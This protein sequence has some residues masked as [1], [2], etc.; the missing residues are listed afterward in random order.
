MTTLLARLSAI[1]LFAAFA[2]AAASQSGGPDRLVFLGADPAEGRPGPIDD[3]LSVLALQRLP[4][5]QAAGLE[6]LAALLRAEPVST[7]IA[8]PDSS[9]IVSGDLSLVV[10]L[11]LGG[12]PPG[13]LS[14]TVGEETLG[15]ETLGERLKALADAFNPAARQVAF[16]RVADGGDRFPAALPAL[17]AALESTGVAMS[18]VMVGAGPC[19]G[20]RPGLHYALLGGLPDRPPFGDGDGL[21]SAD[22]ART[23]LAAAL[24]REVQRA[25]PCA[26]R[27]SLIL[28][29]N[30]DPSR[31]LV[32]LPDVPLIPEM[33]S[34]VYMEAF[35]A[36]F[37]MSSDDDAAIRT[38]LE[39]C[40]FCPRE[41]ELSSRLAQ[42]GEEA[43][44]LSLETRR[45]A[46]DHRRHRAR[47]APR[48]IS[49]TASSAPS[50]S[51]PKAHRRA[52]GRRRRPR[53]RGR[54]LRDS[55]RGARSARPSGLDRDSASPATARPT[56]QALIDDIEADDRVPG[57]RA[58]LKS[59][60]SVQQ[61]RRNRRLAVVLRD[62]RRREPG[63][64]RAARPR[65][66]GSGRRALH[67]RRRPAAAG[68]PA[69][70]VRD[71]RCGRPRRLRRRACVRIPAT[72]S[73]LTALGRCRAGRRRSVG[74]RRRLRGG[75][76]GRP[77][78]GLR[79]CRPCILRPGR[80]ADR[81][82]RPRRRPGARRASD[83]R[84]AVGRGADGALFAR[85][86]RR[87]RP[88]RCAGD[89]D[90]A[91]RMRAIP[92]HSSLPA[93][94]PVP[95]PAPRRRTPRRCAGSN[96]RCGRATCM[97]TRS[98]P[99]STNVA[100]RACRP[101]PSVPPRST[102]RLWPGATRPPATA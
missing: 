58:E 44:A 100:A 94:S 66:R 23:W 93:I 68:R 78:A 85:P 33:E 48:S 54:G 63:R 71:R 34:A 36:L 89:R 92:S 73:P 7:F 27:Y 53:R 32:T 77:A 65:R 95:A 29:S 102:G 26:A 91:G 12:D 90:G 1:C 83:G 40:R 98:S 49:R 13:G 62:L 3:A 69:P 96:A 79:P 9:G 11:A 55:G 82:L 31:T 25:A 80:R 15:V 61:R 72:R 8:T 76:G 47:P 97:P 43:L 5:A 14:V 51:R 52:R 18:V 74:R 30:D 87:Q 46:P 84:L 6:V 56:R 70:L 75:D 88:C 45:L 99:R 42:I 38:Y 24:A 19:E 41:A 39:S 17:R 59:R 21:V 16:V 20:E 86:D 67:R 101:T 10:D 22:E 35:E 28:Q 81:R 2:T 4:E 64:G 60:W 37:L 50:R 57:G